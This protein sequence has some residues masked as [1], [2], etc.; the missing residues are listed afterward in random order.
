[1]KHQHSLPSK[2]EIAGGTAEGRICPSKVLLNEHFRRVL[3]QKISGLGQ[4]WF[5]LDHT[6]K[7][8]GQSAQVT[9]RE[10]V[11]CRSVH[12]LIHL[13]GIKRPRQSYICPQQRL[14]GLLSSMAV[15]GP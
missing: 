7:L 11:S 4:L 5:P 15:K 14:A 2:A 9:G 13:P 1:M 12:C 10:R 8:E 6:L 3:L